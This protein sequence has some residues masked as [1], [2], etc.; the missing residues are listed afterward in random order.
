MLTQ[1]CQVYVKSKFLVSEYCE[2][3]LSRYYKIM[4]CIGCGETSL[5]SV[6]Q[7][8]PLNCQSCGMVWFTQGQLSQ[9]DKY[10]IDLANLQNNGEEVEEAALSEHC[11]SCKLSLH[12]HQYSMAPH[13]VILECYKCGGVGITSKQLYEILE[14]SMS[15]EQYEAYLSQLTHSI[16]DFVEAANGMAKP[17]AMSKYIKFWQ[18]MRFWAK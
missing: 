6:V 10:R 9:I 4:Q 16:P 18:R 1:S 11:A 3:F 12:A 8:G 13:V 5:I 2:S 15:A 17:S 14:N 7:D